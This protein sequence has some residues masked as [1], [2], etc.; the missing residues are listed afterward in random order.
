MAETVD[1]GSQYRLHHRMLAAPDCVPIMFLVRCEEGRWP[2]RYGVEPATAAM[3]CMN[4]TSW[5]ENERE[6]AI[7]C[8]EDPQHERWTN[9]RPSVNNIKCGWPRP[10]MPEV[11][12]TNLVLVDSRPR[13]PA[14]E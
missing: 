10:K 14:A 8:G 7:A 5:R 12:G 9:G 4:G 13:A 2:W 3:T 11:N 1:A 6:A